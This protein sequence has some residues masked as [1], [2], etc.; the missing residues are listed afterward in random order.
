MK[1]HGRPTDILAAL[2]VGAVMLSGVW[3]AKHSGVA[4]DAGAMLMIDSAAAAA[5]LVLQ[6]VLSGRR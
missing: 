1:C 4:L 6:R 5:Y 3:S 2:L